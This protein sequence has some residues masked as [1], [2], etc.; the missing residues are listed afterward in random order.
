LEI[1]EKFSPKEVEEIRRKNEEI[2]PRWELKK[3]KDKN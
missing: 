3:L 1:L 2:D